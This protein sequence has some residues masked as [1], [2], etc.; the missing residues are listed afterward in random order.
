M[1]F[2]S[3]CALAALALA[4]AGVYAADKPPLP[5][6]ASAYEPR[7]VDE[8]GLWMEAD[9]AERRLR[10]SGFV[11]R[12]PQLNAYVK[13]VLCRA[14]GADRC[15]GARIYV[16]RVAAFN[17]N[18]APNGMMQVWSGLLLRARDEAELAAVLGHEFAHFEQRHGVAG[19]KHARSMTDVAVWAGFLGGMTGSVVSNAAIGAIFSYD[20]GREQEADLLGARYLAAAGYDP[21]AF[22]DIWARMM[23]EADATALGRKQ[24]S[25]RYDRV[26]FFATHPTNLERSTY[27]R[28][29]AANGTG[30]TGEAEYRAAM[31]P[32]RAQFLADQ[33]KLNDFG[34]SE[35]LIGQLAREEWSEDL[36]F[37]RAELY[38]FRGNPRDLVTA[39]DLYRRALALDSTHAEALRGLGLSLLRSGDA[40]AGAD[41]LRRY[42]ALRPGAADAAMITTLIS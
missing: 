24:R 21:Q 7:G 16:L 30:A 42:L 9:E 36:L 19:F 12:D 28:R 14:V 13:G 37:A 17:A 31:K 33:L 23:D 5:P 18:M 6:F 2:V 39:A 29:L 26:A 11:I 34:G 35:Y 8:R 32:W 10:D 27:L 3:R 40:A 22:P 4:S 1:H 41:A 15:A 25:R 20:R 38:R